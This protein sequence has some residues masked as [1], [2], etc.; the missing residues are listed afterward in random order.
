[1]L[2]DVL[3]TRVLVGLQERLIVPALVEAFAR[4]HIEEVNLASGTTSA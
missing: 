2:S 1:V 3:L 4:T